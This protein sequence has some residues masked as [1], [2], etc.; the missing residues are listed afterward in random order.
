MS[1]A[2][3][4]LETT[5]DG[6]LSLLMPPDWV[7]EPP[8]ASDEDTVLVAVPTD[9]VDPVVVVTRE[10]VRRDV[11]VSDYLTGQVISLQERQA[12]HR[13]HGGGAWTIEGLR[14]EWY[15]YGHP[16]SSGDVMTVLLAAVR[17]ATAAYLISCGAL[18]EN[19][20][21]HRPTLERI[22]QSVRVTRD[23]RLADQP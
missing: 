14:I 9:G 18:E 22:V 12:G 3:W 11:S 6:G 23:E 10:Q 16:A 17:S 21:R 20:A 4:R 8:D 1:D 13:D 19:F 5:A 15:C 2:A 7:V